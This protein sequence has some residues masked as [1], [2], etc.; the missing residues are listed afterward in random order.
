VIDVRS[1]TLPPLP[2]A[3][4]VA[5]YRIVT[6]AMTNVIRHAAAASCTVTFRL[7]KDLE[8]EIEDD[9][10]GF[11]T[12]TRLGIGVNSMRERATE[13]GGTLEIA[14]DGGTRISAHLPV[15]G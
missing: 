9:G 15:A 12:G 14:V 1:N 3:V 7:A 6:E 13:L 11:D 4:E 8:I 2:A 5:A 10:T